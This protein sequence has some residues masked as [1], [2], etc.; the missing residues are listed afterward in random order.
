[1]NLNFVKP[2]MVEVFKTNISSP[3]DA[4][5]FV[6]LLLQRYP[7]L[8]I[9]MDLDDCDKILRVAGDDVPSY[10]IKFIACVH[11]FEVEELMD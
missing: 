1:M 7:D 6:A 5:Q 4:S 8:E 10:A 3:E 2:S 9:N 11:G